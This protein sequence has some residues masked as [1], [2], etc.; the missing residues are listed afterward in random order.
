MKQKNEACTKKQYL[1]EVK[2]LR[3]AFPTEKGSLM[4]VNGVDLTLEKGE[5]LGL[6]GES[7]CGKSMTALSILRLLPPG[8]KITG[9]EVNL[10]GENL[11]HLS[12][13]KMRRLRG[14]KISMIFQDPHMAL[15][16]VRTV[17]SQF[18]ETLRERLDLPR[19]KARRRAAEMLFAMELA[20]PEKVMKRYPFQLSGGMRQRVMIAMTLALDPDI[21]IADEPTTAL[22]V[23]VQAQI[24]SEMEKLKNNLDTGILLISH[25]MGVI[26]QLSDRVAVMYAGS[27]VEEGPASLIFSSPA[28]PYTQALLHSIPNINRNGQ[29]L[30]SI[31]GQPPALNAIPQG[32]S[33]A[34]RCDAAGELC[35]TKRP[36][37]VKLGEGR[38]LAC[39]FPLTTAGV[40]QGDLLKAEVM[41]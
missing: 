35:Y 21:L 6:V 29:Q 3:V 32:C 12:R 34:P 14:R 10:E 9:G 20:D 17:G 11:L 38:R 5:V 39:F 23:T 28:H 16:P 36:P 18:T 15:N 30:R 27:I 25:N 41:S 26:A 22:D 7:A 33:F 1:L 24:L 2:D 40:H 19:E 37:R 8:G 13:E 31:K 4:A